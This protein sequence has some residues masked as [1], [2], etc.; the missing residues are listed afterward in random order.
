MKFM[1]IPILAAVAISLPGTTEQGVRAAD[2][3]LQSGAPDAGNKPDEPV[4][5]SD[6]PGALDPKDAWSCELILPEYR[7]W[8]D[9]GNDPADWKFVGKTFRD[10]RDSA[11]YTWLDW[12]DWINE[13]D[14]VEGGLVKPEIAPLAAFSILPA[15]LTTAPVASALALNNDSPG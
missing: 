8:L 12:I 10:V 4:I 13:N 3:T 11:T 7:A 6:S 1:F 2:V 15:L 14:C 9:E 5:D